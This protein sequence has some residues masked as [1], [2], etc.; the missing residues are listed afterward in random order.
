VFG[1]TPNILSPKRVAITKKRKLCSAREVGTKT[2]SSGS[3]AIWHMINTPPGT[4]TTWSHCLRPSNK[5]QSTSSPHRTSLNRR[6][7][8]I[9]RR[10]V[11][12]PFLLKQKRNPMTL[13]LTI[14]IVKSHLSLRWSLFVG[15]RLFGWLGF[16]RKG[17][18]RDIWQSVKWVLGMVRFMT[19]HLF[20]RMGSL[21]LEEEVDSLK[22]WL[23]SLREARKACSLIFAFWRYLFL[24]PS[25]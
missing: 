12:V 18:I 2:T 3:L 1:K 14:I 15:T 21:S 9:M 8:D 22:S 10:A 17:I 4:T 25:L 19:P 20:L 13:P 23:G 16:P 24:S 6:I 7:V 11:H 5:R